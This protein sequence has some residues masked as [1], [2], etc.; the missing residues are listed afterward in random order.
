MYITINDV[1]GEKTI[2]LSYSIHS[3][4]GWGK[5]RKEIA[6]VGMHIAVTLRFCYVDL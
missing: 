2:D 4:V 6:V 1:I 5:A 3:T